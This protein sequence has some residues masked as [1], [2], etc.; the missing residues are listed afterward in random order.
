VS[1]LGAAHGDA[2]IEGAA[3]R[4]PFVLAVGASIA[5]VYALWLLVAWPAGDFPLNDD[6]A[7]AWSVRH[8]LETGE[9]RISEWASA[10][11]LLQVYWGALFAKFAGG[12]SFESLRVSTLVFSVASPVALCWLLRRLDV[13]RS[14]AALAAITLLANP[15]FVNLSYTFMTDVFHLGLM[16]VGLAL[17]VDGIERNS[18]RAL[19][20]ASVVAAAAFLCRQLGL[21]LPLAA[22]VVLVARHRRAAF[23][24]VLQAT[25][26]PLAVFAGYTLWLTFVH[27]MTWGFELQV[28]QNSL[29]NLVRPSAPRVLTLR[30]VYAWLYLGLFSLPALIAVLVSAPLDADRVRRLRTPFACWALLC[31]AA[32]W[33]TQDRIGLEMPYLAG[34]ITRDGIGGV[35]IAGLKPRVTPDWVFTLVGIVAPVAGAAIAALWTEVLLHARRELAGRGAVVLLAALI[36]AAPTAPMVSLWDE[37]LL[38]FLPASLYLALRH[39]TLSSRGVAAGALVCTAMLAYAL[40]EQAETLAWNDARWKLGRELVAKGASPQQINGGFEWVGWYDFETALPLSIAA[41]HHDDLFHWASVLPDRWFMAFQPLGVERGRSAVAGVV[42]YRTRFGPG[43]DVYA[44]EG[45]AP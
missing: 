37:Y 23:R 40:P 41:G 1:R 22:A 3:A 2:R 27:G 16:L 26:V 6:W 31:I 17:Y 7:Y 15:I 44:L 45:A 25:L 35:T 19:W 18:A 24:P 30:L 43:G 21:A 36:M 12:F 8:F 33:Y 14:A 5:L 11:A 38:V 42:H 29:P 9:L 20:A 39:V 28:L 13:G 10:A 4:A 34:V 32:T